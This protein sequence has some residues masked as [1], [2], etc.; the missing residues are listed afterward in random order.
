M[1]AATP[2]EALVEVD[3]DLELVRAA[4]KGQLAAFEQLA[5]KYERIVLAVVQ[6]IIGNREEAEATAVE[7]FFL[8]YKALDRFPESAKFSTWLVRIAVQETLSRLALQSVAREQFLDVPDTNGS[9]GLPLEPV[10]WVTSPTELY[11]AVELREILSSS[12]RSVSPTARLVFVLRDIGGVSLSDIVEILGLSRTTVREHL[13]QTRLKLRERLSRYFKT[14]VGDAAPL[15]S[16]GAPDHAA[17]S[18]LHC[19][20][21]E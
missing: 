1:R 15:V 11:D 14:R 5:R 12:L 19:L 2:S 6:S 4:V 13:F 7:V 18:V 10:D 17:F 3:E 20:S 16:V 8:A 21:Q 9:E